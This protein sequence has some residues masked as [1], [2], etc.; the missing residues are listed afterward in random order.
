[1][2]KAAR[3]SRAEPVQVGQ[4]F[5]E[6]LVRGLKYCQQ[7]SSDTWTDYNEHDPG[8]TILEQLC[9]ALTD[10]GAR[11]EQ[12]MNDLLVSLPQAKGIAQ[13]EQRDQQAQSIPL[14]DAQNTLYTGDYVLSCNALTSKDY[15]KLLYD[16]VLGLKN[17]WL[18]PFQST[19]KHA[20]AGCYEVLVE[21][22]E[23]SDKANV[24]ASV[25]E[26]MRASRNL[27][28][29]IE[30]VVI[31]EPYPIAL[32][33]TVEI[34]TKADPVEVLAEVLFQLQ[35][36]LSPFPQ[37]KTVD[38]LM[39]EGKTAD[40]IFVGPRLDIGILDDSQLSPYKQKIALQDLLEI[41]LKVPGVEGVRDLHVKEREASHLQKSHRSTATI[42]ELPP[43]TIPC[44]TPSIF[45]PAEEPY[46]LNIE[47]VGGAPQ[48]LR[49]DLV[50]RYIEKRLGEIANHETYAKRN[51][52]NMEYGKAMP[53]KAL[54]IN[55]YFSIQHQFP[56]T[57]GISRYGIPQ[58]SPWVGAP[59]RIKQTRLTQ[60]YLTQRKAHAQQLKAYLAFFEQLLTNYLAQL[61]QASRLFSLDES[62][63][64]SYFFQ[65]L[66]GLPAREQDPPDFIELLRY[67]PDTQTNPSNCY[68]VYLV[69]DEEEILLKSAEL[70]TE[71]KALE[72]KQEIFKCM[73]DLRFYKAQSN[74]QAEYKLVLHS[75]TNE[76]IAYGE[77]YFAH[78]KQAMQE[79]ERLVAFA[80]TL[81]T[82]KTLSCY[83]RILVRGNFAMRVWDENERIM[84][85]SRHIS[86]VEARQQRREEILRYGAFADYYRIQSNEDGWYHITLL[87]AEDAEETVLAH[88]E[89]RF[90]S[91][92]SAQHGIAALVDWIKCLGTSPELQ[93][94]YIELLPK[95]S[96]LPLQQL[97]YYRKKLGE[98][99]K[100]FDPFLERRNR[101]LDHLLAR[102]GES[103]DNH[104]L[105]HLD[106]RDYS[107]RDSFLRELMHWKIAFLRKQITLGGKRGSG[108]NYAGWDKDHNTKLSGFEQ[109][110]WLLL[111]LHGHVTQGGNYKIAQ[112]PL[113]SDDP[114]FH[115]HEIPDKHFHAH[116]KTKQ[117]K[118]F[119][120]LGIFNRQ[121]HFVFASTSPSVITHLFE[122]G[123]DKRNYQ[124]TPGALEGSVS[125]Y[126][127][128]PGE[129][130]PLEIYQAPN[131]E[132]AKR[133]RDSLIQY[134]YKLSQDAQVLYQDEGLYVLEHLLLR[135]SPEQ[136]SSCPCVQHATEL[137]TDTAQTGSDTAEDFYAN[138]ISIF[139]PNWPVRFQSEEFKLFVERIIYENCPA[140]ISAQYYWLGYAEMAQFERLYAN[141]MQSKGKAVHSAQATYDKLDEAAQALK[142]F[143]QQ[144][145]RAKERV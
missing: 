19:N 79:A 95:E 142:D 98:A 130:Q 121:N 126:F 44:L 4:N 64:Q 101:F 15:S 14:N 59:D 20:I 1:M 115:Y 43:D 60:E 62:L 125:I 128:W 72:M 23:G 18:R 94:Q 82:P 71:A 31:L 84:L 75:K 39:R 50:Y 33:G 45:T 9:Y 85:H 88:G 112:R 8:L 42:I 119:S 96:D 2:K 6:L 81:D 117:Q 109:R 144:L 83:L 67:P 46:G 80:I 49:A 58:H 66:V 137:V 93:K 34:G 35:N 47:R 36:Y 135:P 68:I 13:E 30:R 120:T 78:S 28:E 132:A 11:T 74:D 103:F 24:K 52:K 27:A 7:L 99:V 55:S 77:E 51:V 102:F 40:Q 87:N 3:I 56:L 70:S 76:P 63:E 16:R 17:A 53:G 22:Y 97:N 123:T 113:T 54:N 133:A 118:Y 134:L 108:A 116:E 127:I 131:W 26:I 5:A 141:W 10:L 114:P 29:D 140:H 100:Q 138:R 111:G 110:L 145:E 73:R 61:A 104:T 25:E 124:L 65:P 69:D 21:I 86:S 48:P 139:L 92:L 57:Y 129:E 105:H 12:K 143:V 90:E 136:E 107:K 122:H 89:V 38:E 91:E 106:P 41:I 37:V 32:C